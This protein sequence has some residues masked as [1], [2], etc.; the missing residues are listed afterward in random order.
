MFRLEKVP[1]KGRGLLAS[2]P[3]TAGT[4]LERAPAVSLTAEDRRQLDRTGFF[5]YYFADPRTS[6]EDA[7]PPDAPDGPAAL[8]A[9]GLLTFCNHAASPNAEVRWEDDDVGLWALLV[10]LQDIAAGEEITLFYTNISEYSAANLF[11]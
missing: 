6:E 1:G 4:C 10:A 3:I 8:V 9:F 11:I 5:P 7:A 2:G